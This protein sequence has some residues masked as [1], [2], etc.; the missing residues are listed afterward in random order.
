MFALTFSDHHVLPDIIFNR[1]YSINNNIS[2]P[3]KGINLYISHKVNPRSK[4]L[5]SYFTLNN[6]LFGSVKLTKND[7]DEYKYS[8]YGIGFASHSKFVFKDGSM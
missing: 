6:C 8:G 7:L 4:N 3:K 1:Q 2:K 5:N